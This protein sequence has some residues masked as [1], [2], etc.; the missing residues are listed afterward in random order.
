MNFRRF[1]AVSCLLL[2]CLSA[3]SLFAAD[4]DPP[5]RIAFGSCAKQDQPQPIWDAIVAQSPD[6]FLFIGDN[7]YADTEDMDVMWAKYQQLGNQPGYQRLKETCRILATWDDH[8][9]GANDAGAEY[10]K[11]KESQKLFLDFFEEPADS[12]RRK[13]AGIYDAKIFGPEGR[14]VQII[15]LDTRY[16]RSPLKQ[17]YKAGEPG[18]GYRGRYVPNTDRDATMLGDRQWAWL[19]EQLKQPAELRIIASSIQVIPNEH[20][21]EKWGNFPH[22]RQKLFELIR[23]TQAGGVVFISGDRHLAEISKLPADVAGYP[24]FDVTS[25]SLNTPSGNFTPTGVRWVN[26][27][28]PH[29]I[30]LIYFFTNFGLIDVDWDRDD[31][32]LRLQVRDEKGNVVLQQRTTLSELQPPG[33]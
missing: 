30:G 6:M 20:G 23:D 2:V 24:L 1:Q 13:Q 4:A 21:S 17:G 8:D 15:L 16:F 14:R 25:S 10:P 27:V 3:G 31:P 12:P 22:E 19:E 7:I 33:Q 11:K 29:R 5:S 28:N 9:Y 32:L 26:E 18:E